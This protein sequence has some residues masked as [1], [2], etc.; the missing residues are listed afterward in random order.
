MYTLTEQKL[1][2]GWCSKYRMPLLSN[3]YRPESNNILKIN[4]FAWR[5]EG[6]RCRQFCPN[7]EKVVLLL[8]SATSLFFYHVAPLSEAILHSV[9]PTKCTETFHKLIL[10]LSP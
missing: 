8:K 1:S 7:I 3:D 5:V 10:L 2:V 4:N 6:D 9:I